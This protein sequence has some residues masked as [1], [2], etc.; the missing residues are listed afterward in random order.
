MKQGLAAGMA[1]AMI[2]AWGMAQAEPPWR[3]A[4][5]MGMRQFVVVEPSVSADAETLKQAASGV[6]AANRACVV[7]FWSEASAVPKKMPMTRTQ[8]RAVVAQYFRNPATGSE[9]LLLRCQ[10][11][12]PRGQKCLR[13]SGDKD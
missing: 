8:H 12:E 4:G 7:M 1:A 11:D 5:S 2:A 9:E 10:G 13:Q 3:H 6:C